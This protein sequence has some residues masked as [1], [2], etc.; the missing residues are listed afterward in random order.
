MADGTKV[1][2]QLTLTWE[3]YPGLSVWAQYHL[4]KGVKVKD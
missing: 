2:Y 3:Y 1:V 4:K